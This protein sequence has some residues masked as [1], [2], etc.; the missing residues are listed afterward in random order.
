MIKVSKY[1]YGVKVILGLSALISVLTTLGI[2]TILSKETL[3]FFN[4]V[5]PMELL[6]GTAW[7]PLLEPKSFGVLPLVSG[8]L[9]IVFGAGLL[10][11]PIGTMTAVS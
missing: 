6:F 7:E 10:A 5:K 4:L 1:E 11:I 3:P 2:I 8:T 9:L